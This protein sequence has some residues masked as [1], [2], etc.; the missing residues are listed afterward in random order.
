MHLF[1]NLI[2]WFKYHTTKGFFHILSTALKSYPYDSLY[3]YDLEKAKL[4]EMIQHFKTEEMH[5]EETPHIIKEMELAV[6]LID[7]F[8]EETPIVSTTKNPITGK[9]ENQLI[10]KVNTRN[11]HRFYPS[12][13]IS[14]Y[15]LYIL[16]AKSLYHKIRTYWDSSWWT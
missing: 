10:P 7:I 5:F 16:K 12:A 8:T 11:A 3:L 15:F 2:H 6:K 4:L 1:R 14:P 9:L 13:T